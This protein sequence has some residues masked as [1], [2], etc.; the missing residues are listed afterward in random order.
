MSQENV[1]VV[2]S[3][4]EALVDANLERVFARYH[5]DVE[6]HEPAGLPWGRVHRGHD[7]IRRLLTLL[8]QR[9]PAT[10]LHLDRL[11]D[12]GGDEVLVRA[13]LECRGETFPYLERVVVR[14]GMICEVHTHIDTAAMLAHL[15]RHDA[16]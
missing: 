1:A 7:E 14:D 9:F 13:R 11:Y 15:A 4:Y 6:M 8:T 16:L 12:L 10:L 2:R 3:V 5:A